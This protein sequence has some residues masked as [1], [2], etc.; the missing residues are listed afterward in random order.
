MFQ[1]RTHA[2]VSDYELGSGLVAGHDWAIAETWRRFAPGVFVLAKR[3]LGSESEAEDVAQ[4]VFRLVFKK[5]KTL[6]APECL[7]SFVFSFAIRVLKTELRSKSARSWL[8]F[9]R[10][11]TF[12]TVHGELIDMESRD[13][14]RRFYALL[15]RL[16]PR[17]RLVFALRHLESMTLEEVATHME[18]SLSTVKRALSRATDQLAR[19]IEADA[20]LAHVLEGCGWRRATCPG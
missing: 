5:S 13:L 10:P 2:S 18:M 15:D 12:V 19:L 6:R 1:G 3:T 8:S 7:R 4:D 9:C 11:E 14:L 16:T 20:G 17:N